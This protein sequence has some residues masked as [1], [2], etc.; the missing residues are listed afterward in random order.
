MDYFTRNIEGTWHCSS[1]GKESAYSAG[2]PGSIPGLGRSPG[3][4]MATHPSILPGEFHGQRCPAGYSPWGRKESDT[5]ERLSLLLLL[6]RLSYN[7][8]NITN[9][10]LLDIIY[11]NIQLALQYPRS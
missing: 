2:D 5:T 10:N 1:D 7:K 4:E 9:T 3:E 8:I 6:E 11:V